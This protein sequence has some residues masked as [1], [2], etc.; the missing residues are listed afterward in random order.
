M[1]NLKI[2]Q[3][4]KRNNVYDQGGLLVT[5]HKTDVIIGLGIK[6]S[7]NN[8]HYC[9]GNYGKPT[10]PGNCNFKLEQDILK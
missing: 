10:I 6:D 8:S 4:C 3:K 2:C 9:D 5:L 7:C 1:K